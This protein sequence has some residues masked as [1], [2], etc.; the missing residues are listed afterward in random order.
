MIQDLSLKKLTDIFKTPSPKIIGLDIGTRAVKLIEIK[1]SPTQLE[2]SF[3]GC[4]PLS[5]GAI[6]EKTIVRHDEVSQAISALYENSKS[7]T[8]NVSISLAGKAI[9][10]KQATMTAM[11]D[12]ELEKLI[13]IEA[14]PYIPYSM[15][16]VDLDFFILG[17]TP[18][19]PGFMDV[20]LVAVRKDFMGDYSNLLMSLDFV[21]TV[22]DVDCFALEVMYDYCYPDIE[23]ETIALINVGAA[24]TNVNILKS[25]VSHFTRD[26][27]MGGD[28]IT[29]DIARFF[30]VDFDRAENMKF[31]GNLGNISPRTLENI[32]ARH[33]EL[34]A[35]E[36][37][38]TL[39]FFTTN[40][41]RDQVKSIFLSGGASA[42]Y[43]FASALEGE[44][45]IPV[46]MVDPFRLVGVDPNVFD[47][48]Y[49]IQVGP[50][51]AVAVG[52]ALRHERDKADA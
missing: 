38:R 40:L 26:L 12:Q 42:T 18:D 3:A 39:E 24:L 20:V 51:M 35:S 13:S 17:E 16:E 37:K 2:L 48:D 41:E 52:L 23:D 19:K 25:G 11:G 43:G 33:V 6:V 5:E 46:H 34:F 10:V 30:N 7:T 45:G 4:C 32:F 31:G 29:R 15:D 28:L 8:R 44:T 1:K 47:S 21:P 36:L 50:S 22:V 49:L 27:P 9:I 14:E